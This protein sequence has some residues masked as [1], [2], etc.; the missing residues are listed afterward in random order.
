MTRQSRILCYVA[1]CLGLPAWFIAD[2]Y[3]KGAGDPSIGGAIM[4]GIVIFV[5]CIF[6]GTAV[7][8]SVIESIWQWIERRNK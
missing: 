7:A 2:L 1:A 8:C 4:V 5:P 6:A 3:R